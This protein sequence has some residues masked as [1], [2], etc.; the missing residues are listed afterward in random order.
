MVGTLWSVVASVQSGLL[1][2]LPAFL[3]PS[4]ACGDVTSWTRCLS[5]SC[6]STLKTNKFPSIPMYRSTVPSGCWLTIW[7]LKTL[8]YNV[9]GSLAAEGILRSTRPSDKQS[10]GSK[11]EVEAKDN[12]LQQPRTAILYV[13]L[14]TRRTGL[15]NFF[16]LTSY[17]R[18]RGSQ[19]RYP[20]FVVFICDLHGLGTFVVSLCLWTF[21]RVSFLKSMVHRVVGHNK[22]LGSVHLMIS[23]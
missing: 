7:S 13:F 8:S 11:Q 4:K 21:P 9:L 23:C 22:F 19:I 1:T 5:A 20:S 2:F 16:S 17:G 3:R 14:Q 6:Q 15:L 18:S 10:I 12:L